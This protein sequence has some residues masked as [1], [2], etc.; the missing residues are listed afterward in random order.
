M[1]KNL[2][3]SDLKTIIYDLEVSPCIGWFWQTGTQY[4]GAHNIR[5]SGKIICVSYRFTHWKKGVVKH[6]VWDKKQCDKK[7]V[8]DFYEI[9]K[10]ADLIVG[11]NGDGFD[12]KWLN[13]RLAYHHLP[14]LSH[15]NTEDTLKQVRR[16]FKL[17]S[18]R[19]DFLCKY[20]NIGGKLATSS[21]LWTGVVFDKC[22]KKLK[23]MVQYCD[24]D[25]LILAELYNR[26]YP[27]V[28]HKYNRAVLENKPDICPKCGSNETKLEGFA[29]TKVGK[30]QRKSC[31]NCGTWFRNGRNLIYKSS[32]FNR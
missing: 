14:T 28:Q 17:P 32:R 9:A 20:F 21:D 4:I 16:E 22:K 2:T 13:A 31:K 23:Q 5:E 6:L 30:Y 3:N 11:H 25:V 18:Y 27:Y 24:N 29:Y 7:L 1:D 26:L 8:K 12:K 10:S 15:V 19:L